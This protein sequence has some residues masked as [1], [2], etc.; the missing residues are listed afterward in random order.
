MA[1]RMKVTLITA[2]FNAMASLPQLLESLR[3]QT[4]RDFEFIVIDGASTDG[5]QDLL[6]ASSD[7]VSHWISEPDFGIYDALN[8][9]IKIASGD[10]YL[11][12]GADDTLEPG[13]LKRYRDAAT[14]TSAD[15][16]SAPVWANGRLMPVHVKSSWLRGGPPKVS[17]HSVGALIRTDLHRQLGLYS[18][19]L[20]I[21][22]DT[23]FLA[24]ADVAGKRFASIEEPAGTFGTGGLSSSDALGTLT[25]S[26]RANVMAR[27]H[28]VWFGFLFLLR[29][30]KNFRQIA[31]QSHKHGP[32]T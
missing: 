5:T 13:A 23:L 22:A 25:E 8:K 4:W 1:D 16:I 24:M 31:R 14:R 26:M 15:I 12:A 17:C 18:R 27:G 28:W 19:K 32:T 7:V 9:G 3:Q 11:V 20:P 2:T 10:Y 29:V 30:V 6:A 21:A